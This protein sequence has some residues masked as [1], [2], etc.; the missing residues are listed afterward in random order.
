[1]STMS[2]LNSKV[3][4][5]LAS[6]SLVWIL[7]SVI[8]LK[9]SKDEIKEEERNVETKIDNARHNNESL[10][11][12]IKYFDNPSFLEKEARLRLNYKAPGEEVV[13]VHRDL[14]SKKISSLDEPLEDNL[15]NYKKWWY[16]L[17]GY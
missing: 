12:F 9:I 8:S 1:M 17:L 3:F 2:H 10:E 6:A 5:V 4:T 16:Y 15:P 13:F 11:K 14:N 7:F